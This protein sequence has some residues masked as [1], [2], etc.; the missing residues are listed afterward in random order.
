MDSTLK[1]EVEALFGL[2]LHNGYGTTETSPTLC[3]S[4]LGEHRDGVS[5]GPP[6]PGVELRIVDADG[7]DVPVGETG[8]V[9]A[10]SP[11]VMLGYFR[12]PAATAAAL[13]GGWLRTSDLARFDTDGDLHLVGRLKDMI[14]RSGFNV[15]PAEVEAV[16]NAHEG[17]ALSAVVGR[18]ADRN[19]EVV[20]F[21]QPR[22][23]ANI[24]GVTLAAYLRDCI[25][26]YKRPTRFFFLDALPTLP[27]GRIERS[28]LKAIA[29]SLETVRSRTLGAL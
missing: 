8:E 4:R 2:P 20:A 1:S 23:G 24:D 13:H 16:I 21:V 17:V 18:V 15:Y 11:G 5:V 14:I 6:I 12:D 7:V 25:A 26:P 27:N 9:W 28:A 10:R 29:Q 19:E 3:H 22:P